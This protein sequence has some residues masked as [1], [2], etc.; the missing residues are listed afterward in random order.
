MWLCPYG[1]TPSEVSQAGDL[2]FKGD[3]NCQYSADCANL[4]SL[5]SA[6]PQN[7]KTGANPGFQAFIRF[8]DYL[9][10]AFSSSRMRMMARVSRRSIWLAVG[11]RK[12]SRIPLRPDAKSLVRSTSMD[13]VSFSLLTTAK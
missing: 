2:P 11:S 5:C 4:F 13:L 6:T 1:V 10:S 12:K 9:L 3:G 7:K 8:S